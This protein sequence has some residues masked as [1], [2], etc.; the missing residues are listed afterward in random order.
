MGTYSVF[1]CIYAISIDVGRFRG[2]NKGGNHFIYTHK[3]VLN[4][5]QHPPIK[6]AKVRKCSVPIPILKRP[7]RRSRHTNRQKK[8]SII[9]YYVYIYQT[10]T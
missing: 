1:S 10:T 8:R 4:A 7:W 9:L 2:S 3:H 5:L 6:G